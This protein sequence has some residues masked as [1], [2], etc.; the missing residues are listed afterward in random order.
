MTAV[1]PVATRIAQRALA[2]R[3]AD[4]AGEVRRLLDAALAVMCAGGTVSRP[5]VADIVAA[6]G[7]SNEAFYRH[8]R[9]KDALVAALLEDGTERLLSY[10][11]HRMD[12]ADSPEAKVREWVSC[13]L[14]QAGG[15]TAAGTMAVLWN[16]GGLGWELTAGPPSPSR[17]LAELLRAPLAAL[18]RPDPDFDA[19]MAG[20]A[21]VGL[22]S[23]YLWRRVEPTTADIDRITAYC[24]R[25]AR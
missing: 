11:A 3:G 5:R 1:D 9:S 16:A 12:K 19:T 24:L 18:G 2:K 4:Y 7:L 20:H 25:P 10:V 22:L 13:V 6:A 14:S 21:T 17:A 8:F 23:D 15:D